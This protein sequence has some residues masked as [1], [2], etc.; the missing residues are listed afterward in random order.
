[1]LNKRFTFTLLTLLIIAGIAGIAVFL[2]KG[3]RVSPQTGVISGTGIISVTSVPDQA[4]VYLDGHLTT[5]TNDNVN[6][7]VP[8]AYDIRIVKEGYIPWQKKIDVKEGLVSEIKATLFRSIPT[9]YPLSYSGA[10]KLTVSPD[11]LKMSYVVP[12]SEETNLLSAKK[13]GV[14]VWSTGEGNALNF[15]RNNDPRQIAS[16]VGVDYSQ[17]TF[18]FSPDS[19]QLLVSF[20]DRYLLMD[21]DRFNDPPK[22]ITAVIQATLKTWDQTEAK[23]RLGRLQLIKD[24]NIRKTAS[25]SAT[26]KWSKD[27]TRILYQATEADNFQVTDLTS[28]K[29]YQLASAKGYEW[30][31]DSDH[32]I[33]IEYEKPAATKAPTPS[34]KTATTEADLS[35]LNQNFLPTKISIV[36]IDGLN[37]SEIYYG[38]L[39]PQV[40]FAWPDSSRLVVVSSLPTATA[41]K[42]NLYGI[43]LK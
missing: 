42:P 19:T 21:I 4:S 5:A 24:P 22:D 9:V 3:Y 36:E 8:K 33:M 17:A 7:L 20:P 2:A 25:D 11:R 41:S 29:T 27:E 30:L 43:N 31:P 38:N 23:S 6:S 16:S 10:Q 12:D 14:W 34:P 26:L 13:G 35:Q 15:T 40:V 28:N 1:M 37:K 39:D 18:R 32:L